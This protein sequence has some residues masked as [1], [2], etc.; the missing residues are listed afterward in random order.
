MGGEQT[1]RLWMKIEHSHVNFANRHN[2]AN[3]A[4]SEH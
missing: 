4:N 2:A 1:W 3:T